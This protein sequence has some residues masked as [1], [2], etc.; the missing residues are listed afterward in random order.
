MDLSV[1]SS[2]SEDGFEVVNPSTSGSDDSYDSNAAWE[3]LPG[4][5]VNEERVYNFK[6]MRLLPTTLLHFQENGF[7]EWTSSK[8][9]GILE[10]TS[11]TWQRIGI[12]IGE[13]EKLEHGL[14]AYKNGL[15]H[16]NDQYGMPGGSLADG[17]RLRISSQPAPHQAPHF[18]AGL[19]QTASRQ[20][21]D[22]GAVPVLEQ[23]FSPSGTSPPTVGLPHP[24]VVMDDNNVLSPMVLLASI[25]AGGR[26]AR[27]SNSVSDTTRQQP[28]VPQHEVTTGPIMSVSMVAS[29]VILV[30]FVVTLLCHSSSSDPLQAPYYH[31]KRGWVAFKVFCVVG[32]LFA[33][34]TWLCFSKDL[35]ILTGTGAGVAYASII[36]ATAPVHCVGGDTRVLNA[37]RKE[38]SIS[39]MMVGEY[40]LA[41]SKRKYVVC[42]I[43]EKCVNMVPGAEVSE[44]VF[45][46]SKQVV[47][48]NNHPFWVDGKKW[49]SVEPQ[50]P[51]APMKTQQLSVGD[52]CRD[53]NGKAVQVKAVRSLGSG[54]KR[55]VFNLVVDGAGSWFANGVLTHSGMQAKVGKENVRWNQK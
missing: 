9:G 17:L 50:G 8:G 1:N 23:Q 36:F 4:V 5:D 38:V 13:Q 27:S 39:D 32:S 25:F 31:E 45:G 52:V 47:A 10:T 49:C 16:F 33:A 6:N 14:N 42:R 30:I 51:A 40:V 2:I 29:L 18:G 12:P 24:S 20:D 21:P 26:A 34:P 37:E 44:I 46:E 43:L 11:T 7:T 19:A 48:T 53:V 28:S 54:G 55:E 15:E 22:I 3:N 41:W 35:G